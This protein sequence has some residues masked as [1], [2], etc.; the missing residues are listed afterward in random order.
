MYWNSDE[1]RASDNNDG[2]NKKTL[3]E[4]NHTDVE[5]ISSISSAHS[6]IFSCLSRDD[7]AAGN[8]ANHE[9]SLVVSGDAQ[10]Q[11]SS[12]MSV[13]KAPKAS[14]SLESEFKLRILLVKNKDIEGPLHTIPKLLILCRGL[15]SVQIVLS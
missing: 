15:E 14:V 13:L 1:H 8:H 2:F 10:L 9:T 7:K 5:I 12:L 6:W 3:V 4:A 11:T